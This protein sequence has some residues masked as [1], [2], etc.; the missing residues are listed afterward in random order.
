MRGLPR[1]CLWETQ[2]V[3]NLH[4]S[5]EVP[6]GSKGND[7]LQP[8]ALGWNAD[9]LFL[10]M[11]DKRM[12]FREYLEPSLEEKSR[13]P[14]YPRLEIVFG[15]GSCV[16]LGLVGHA[17]SRIC[18]LPDFW[19]SGMCA[20]CGSMCRAVESRSSAGSLSHIPP[21]RLLSRALIPGLYLPLIDCLCHCGAD[22]LQ[23]SPAWSL[24]VGAWGMIIP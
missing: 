2:G 10:Q 13:F 16:Q 3:W 7:T 19:L 22:I 1:N 9:W 6:V 12:K 21:T 11:L 24:I 20:P 8:T 17:C 18:Q 15:S 4:P 14:V 5:N 23:G